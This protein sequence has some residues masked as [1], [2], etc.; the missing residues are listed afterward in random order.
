MVQPTRSGERMVRANG[1]DLCV[2]TFGDP[3]DH[4]V[5][6][7]SG[8]ASSMMFW[9][10]EFCA[11]LAG[12]DRFVLRYDHRDTGRSVHYPAGA[13]GYTM[14]D[15]IEDPIGII[16][17]Y[18]LGRVHV[19]GISMGGDIA[20]QIGL[21]HADRV[22]SL[23]LLSTS[24]AGPGGG[25][26]LPGMTDEL[27]K[28]F[29]TAATPDWTDRAAVIDSVIEFEHALRG[30]L[31]Y[32]EAA[33]RAGYAVEYERTNDLAAAP[34]NHFI[35]PSAGRWNA[36]ASSISAPTLVI[37]GT[38]DPLLPFEHGEALARTIPGARLLPL[39]RVGHEMPPPTWGTVVAAIVDHTA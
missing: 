19:V 25:N 37:H 22:A 27:S 33:A 10:D 31:P 21:R 32:D 36:D 24:A 39:E 14:G 17:A 11:N 4:P 12:A 18:G 15:L 34:T 29:A 3:T 7:I 35:L 6:L 1:V 16:D 5:L 28:Y 9:T 38:E 8:G 30:S 13:P 26:G 2:E 20:L 23:T